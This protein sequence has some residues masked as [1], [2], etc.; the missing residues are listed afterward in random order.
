MANENEVKIVPTKKRRGAA[1]KE[2]PAPVE[3]V[4]EKRTRKRTAAKEEVAEEL[5]SEGTSPE[6]EADKAVADELN[7]SAEEPEEQ[8]PE[9][10]ATTAADEVIDSDAVNA[11]A[12]TEKEMYSES[13][14]PPEL[15]EEDLKNTMHKEKEKVLN[16]I[17]LSTADRKESTVNLKGVSSASKSE[18]IALYSDGGVIPLGDSLQYVSEGTRRRDNFIEL[19]NSLRSHNVLTG[20]IIST[21]TQYGHLCAVV[22]YGYFSVTIPSEKFLTANEEKQLA[23]EK[24]EAEKNHMLRRFMNSRIGAEIDFIIVGIDENEQVAIGDRK[25]AMAL[26]TRA[27]YLTTNS[28]G[29]YALNK[30]TKVEARVAV[31]TQNQMTVEV[32][33]MEYKLREKDISYVRVPDISKEFPVGSTVPVVFTK[34]ERVKQ[35]K[36]VAIHAS[37]SVKDALMDPRK[38]YFDMYT[39]NSVITGTVTGITEDGIYVRLEGMDGRIDMMCAFPKNAPAPGRSPV[40]PTIGTNV[41][42]KV[43]KKEETDSKNRPIFRMYGTII[44][45][46]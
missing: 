36:N 12:A 8:A 9:S 22:R 19:V 27:W 28:Q 11:D 17:A 20:R 5:E 33:G 29:Q 4:V 13:P 16:Q 18:K 7:A 31:A 10:E 44:R 39:L 1:A 45:T 40:L 23:E 15:K 2:E 14:L 34:L 30:G 25:E 37:V 32:F 42:C 41:L 26:K 38:R 46:L 3:E 43:L 24:N 6:L 21:T 35:G